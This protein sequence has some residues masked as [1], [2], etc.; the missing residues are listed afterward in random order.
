M[1]GKEK[2]SFLDQVSYS[3]QLLDSPEKQIH[4]LLLSKYIMCI[5]VFI[6][7]LKQNFHVTQTCLGELLMVVLPS[8]KRELTTNECCSNKNNTFTQIPVSLQEAKK[9]ILSFNG[10]VFC[11]NASTQLS[12]NYTN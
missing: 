6:C 10:K 4:Q 2:E 1:W 3:F 8:L 11:S 7:Q 5:K 12:K 9:S